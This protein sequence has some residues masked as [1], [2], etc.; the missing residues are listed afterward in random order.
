MA[1][2]KTNAMR[3]LDQAK[4][5]YTVYTYDAIDD[6]IDG[7]S[8]AK[9]IGKPEHLLYKTLVTCGSSKEHYVFVV[10][11]GSSLDLKKAA[12][13]V[14]EKSVEMVRVDEINKLTGYIRGGCSPVG[15]KKLFHTIFDQS[16]ANLEKI[17]VSGG[18]IGIQLEMSPDLLLGQV[19]GK[20]ADICAE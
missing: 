12:R 19:R 5:P 2:V 13:A 1:A 6:Q 17:V 9:K 14:G 16:A 3:M 20:L 11:V 4:I 10:P 18:K 7:R 8:V 15:M